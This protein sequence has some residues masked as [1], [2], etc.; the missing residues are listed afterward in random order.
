MKYLKF[1]VPTGLISSFLLSI[2][3]FSQTQEVTV[4]IKSGNK[5]L[6][7]EAGVLKDIADDYYFSRR[8]KLKNDITDWFRKEIKVLTG[9]TMYADQVQ[10][11]DSSVMMIKSENNKPFITFMLPANEFICSVTTPDGLI[12]GTSKFSDSHYFIRYEV[13][14]T[15]PFVQSGD[16]ESIKLMNAEWTINVTKTY[17]SG[18]WSKGRLSRLKA[19]YIQK[20]LKGIYL[21]LNEISDRI[22]QYLQGTVINHPELKYEFEIDESK[23][24]TVTAV[25]SSSSLIFTHKHS[26]TGIVKRNVK[27]TPAGIKDGAESANP[28]PVP[29]TTSPAGATGGRDGQLKPAPASKTLKRKNQR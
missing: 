26:P 4:K 8:D 9:E 19:G 24:L 2:S 15:F 29:V 6:F 13:I 7:R 22:Q 27:T 5:E 28:S 23:A 11:G 17:S 21:S 16:A 20:P 10:L 3:V 1:K 25:E 12:V 18:Y 14:G